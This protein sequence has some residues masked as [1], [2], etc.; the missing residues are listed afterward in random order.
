M[1]DYKALY[2]K[3]KELIGELNNFAYIIESPEMKELEQKRINELESELSALEDTD[4]VTLSEEAQN[5]ITS[6]S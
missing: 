3:Q 5:A 1:K 2:E 4:H 6:A